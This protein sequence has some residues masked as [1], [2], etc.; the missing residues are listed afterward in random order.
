MFIVKWIIRD[1]EN[2]PVYTEESALRDLE[3]IVA[4]CQGR[5]LGG[6]T[7]NMEPPPEGFI[8]CDQEGHVLRRWLGKQSRI[9]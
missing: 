1:E 2:N 4:H 8:I 3:S 6:A 5:L 9:D 7:K